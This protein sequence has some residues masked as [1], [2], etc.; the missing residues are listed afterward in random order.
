M[1]VWLGVL[2]RI[3]NANDD[4]DD[5]DDD[6][7]NNHNIIIIIAGQCLLRET[8]KKMQL[9]HVGKK[10]TQRQ[11]ELRATFYSIL[12]GHMTSIIVRSSSL[13]T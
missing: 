6:N 9:T 12:A 8:T 7:D 5:D 10:K 1:G 11:L 2:R 13:K 3:I 4:D